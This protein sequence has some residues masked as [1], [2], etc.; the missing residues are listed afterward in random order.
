MPESTIDLAKLFQTV[1][2]AMSENKESLNEA[3]SYNQNHGDNMVQIFDTI[4]K[5]VGKKKKSDAGTAF[6]YASK[7]LKK[8]QSSGSAKVYAEGLSRAAETFKSKQVTQENAL[9]LIQSL[10]GGGA[11]Q[12]SGGDLLGSLLGGLGA[13]EPS[14]QTSDDGLD[15]GDL[16]SAGKAFMQSQQQGG[17]AFESIIQA[18]ISGGELGGST[19]RAKSG[20]LVGN[21]LMKVLGALGR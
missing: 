19:H 20:E 18:V 16:I 1:T 2:K 9:D 14:P 12:A 15:M 3:D 4:S 5:A 21:T 17:S 7:A 8:T 11:G 10:L 6:D 13:G